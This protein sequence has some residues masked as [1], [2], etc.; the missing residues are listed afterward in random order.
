[1]RAALFVG[2]KNRRGAV[3][4]GLDESV[5][6]VKSRG[7]RRHAAAPGKDAVDTEDRVKKIESRKAKLLVLRKGI[8]KGDISS[9]PE[10]KPL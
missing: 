3:R 9:D 1:M 5:V 10:K 4:R 2:G 8:D 7:F 6:S